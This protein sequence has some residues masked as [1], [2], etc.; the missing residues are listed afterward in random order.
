MVGINVKENTVVKSRKKVDNNKVD[1]AEVVNID[2]P[3]VP[4]PVPVTV[5]E[6]IPKAEPLTKKKTKVAKTVEPAAEQTKVKSKV[7][8][9][10]SVTTKTDNNKADVK[11]KPVNIDV[12]D[13][14]L[15][16]VYYVKYNA[17]IRRHCALNILD[18]LINSG[19]L[20]AD[21]KGFVD[22]L[23]NKI[24]VTHNGLVKEYPY[25]DDMFINC[26]SKA[27]VDVA[28]D[29]QKHLNN[30]IDIINADEALKGRN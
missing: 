9:N 16:V 14:I 2:M 8:Q 30:M 26:I 1:V 22:F 24:R 20:P 6:A 25:T 4:N 18:E 13:H 17:A 10:A 15:N 3:V 19:A 23:W 7:K 29:V 11:G 27:V 21:K 28:H 5:S 12:P